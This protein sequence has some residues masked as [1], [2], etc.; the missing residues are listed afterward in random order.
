MLQSCLH[1]VGTFL[2]EFKFS[3][4]FFLKL[5][6]IIEINKYRTASSVWVKGTS[7]DCGPLEIVAHIIMGLGRPG[8]GILCRD[9]RPVFQSVWIVP[10]LDLHIPEYE[11][12]M[13]RRNGHDMIIP[14]QAASGEAAFS[15]DAHYYITAFSI[16]AHYQTWSHP[17]TLGHLCSCLSN[18][19]LGQ[20]AVKRCVAKVGI[21]DSSNDFCAFHPPRGQL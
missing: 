3:G 5:K 1:F 6:L 19:L 18:G 15:I 8:M 13:G 4:R 16:S 7:Q 2:S 17:P 21:W 20:R 12:R 14:G 11:Q 9:S 10:W